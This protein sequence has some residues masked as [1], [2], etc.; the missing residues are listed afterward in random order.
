M[1]K[2]SIIKINF[3]KKLNDE[4]ESV[5]FDNNSRFIIFKLINNSKAYDLTGKTVRVAGIKRDG[6]EIFND[7]EMV[8]EKNGMV[9]MELTEQINAAG[10]RVVCELKIYGDNDFLLST[11]QFV[12]NVSN[13]VMST[14]ILSSNEFTAL[15]NALKEIN[16]IDKKFAEVSSEIDEKAKQSD[17]EIQKARIDNITTLQEGSTTGDAELVD[18]RVGEDGITYENAGGAVRGQ[19]NEIKRNLVYLSQ[20]LKEI[21]LFPNNTSITQ[22]YYFSNGS[23]KENSS[24]CYTELL[25]ISSL[26]L[27]TNMK[28]YINSDNLESYQIFLNFY[29][30]LNFYKGQ[31]VGKD[32][33]NFTI[34]DGCTHII[35]S[36]KTDNMSKLQITEGDEQISFTKNGI[37]KFNKEFKEIIEINDRINKI[38]SFLQ[39]KKY[40][41]KKSGGA[42]FTSL[43]ECL[44]IATETLDSVVYVDSGEYDLQQEFIDKY[45]ASYWDNI[46]YSTSK[47]GL[48][49]KNRV[50]IV[51]SEN[52]KIIFNYNG[53]NSEVLSKF[54]IFNA[55]RLG[56][57]LVNC[58]IESSN[59]RYC[60][61]D[62]RN[63]EEDSYENNYI[64]CSFKQDNSL[65]SSWHSKQCI[66][67]GLGVNGTINIKDCKFESIG[68]NNGYGIVS[69]HNSLSISAK[70][71]LT[72]TG[73]YFKGNSTF[74]LSGYGQAEQISTALVS[75]NSFGAEIV[76]TKE[77]ESSRQNTEILSWNNE[78]RNS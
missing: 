73:N 69:Y 53:S 66:G 5:Q 63:T 46:S 22:G 42:D 17:L 33:I 3:D 78:I 18:I 71:K 57:T 25:P 34:P 52:A 47:G 75:N 61:H 29:K 76:H 43:L 23:A 38:E 48:E 51:F 30:N 27:K 56:F 65:N 68:I 70:S 26:G 10:G 60:V 16:D 15:T 24:Y 14:K 45:G 59:C 58:T 62:E 28:Y 41:V 6:T 35:F 13:S 12:I 55:G 8:D 31:T 64:N 49:L 2:I 40:Y 67:G 20:P 37:W 7:C 39:N 77:T 32:N 54:S 72:L 36:T 9:S 21:N 11:K 19:F 4:I 1:S 50:K 44:L 74:R